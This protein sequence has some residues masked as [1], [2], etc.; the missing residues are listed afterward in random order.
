ML[1]QLTSLIL[2]GAPQPGAGQQDEEAAP[3]G[4][5]PAPHLRRP[6]D[7]GAEEDQELGIRS[8]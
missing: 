1:F 6:R 2:P 8:R 7:L 4:R 5:P 3:P